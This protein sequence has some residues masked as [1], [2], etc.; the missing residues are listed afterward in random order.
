MP[1]DDGLIEEDREPNNDREPD[2]PGSDGT[3]Y[4]DCDRE[5]D[6]HAGISQEEFDPDRPGDKPY[7]F[8]TR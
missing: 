4:Q 2:D 8:V 6:Q 3:F 1:S 5:P 7:V